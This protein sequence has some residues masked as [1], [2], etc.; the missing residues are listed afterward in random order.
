MLLLEPAL[1]LPQE[2]PEILEI[3]EQHPVQDRVLRMDKEG[4]IP[5]KKKGGLP[6]PG[7]RPC[8]RKKLIARLNQRSEPLAAAAAEAAMAS[9]ATAAE[10]A[11]GPRLVR[12]GTSFVDRQASGP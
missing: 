6:Y 9:A 5:P 4:E 3:M 2:A 8:F 10:T 1:V 12:P 7:I 11:A